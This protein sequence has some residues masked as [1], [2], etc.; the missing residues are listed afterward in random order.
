MLTPVQ[1]II[2]FTC[3]WHTASENNIR[4]NAKPD[5]LTFWNSCF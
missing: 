3:L 4:L 2:V 1:Y 5:G